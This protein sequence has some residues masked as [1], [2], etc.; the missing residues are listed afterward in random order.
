MASN[1]TPTRIRRS[2]RSASDRDC[3]ADL[4]AKRLLPV[5]FNMSVNSD[6]RMVAQTAHFK[7]VHGS[8]IRSTDAPQTPFG[9][10]NQTPFGD[11]VQFNQLPIGFLTGFTI[12]FPIGFPIV[13]PSG[14][15]VSRN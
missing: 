1:S 9:Q 15:A 11:A 2:K 6:P 7:L 13:F 12:C 14:T 3:D 4:P 5:K 10:F 8:P